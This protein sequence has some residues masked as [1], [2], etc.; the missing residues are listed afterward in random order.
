MA[1][2]KK[3]RDRWLGTVKRYLTV[4][5]PVSLGEENQVKFFTVRILRGE[6]DQKMTRKRL[7]QG[8]ILSGMRRLD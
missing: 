2:L 8:H 1:R 4:V 5:P 6:N 7:C 3:A